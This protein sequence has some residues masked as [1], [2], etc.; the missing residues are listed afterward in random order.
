MQRQAFTFAIVA[1]VFAMTA[2]PSAH[3][4]RSTF[5]VDWSCGYEE[6]D[7]F[8]RKLKRANQEDLSCLAGAGFWQEAMPRIGGRM[9]ERRQRLRRL[10][11]LVLENDQE[12]E[13]FFI[14]E[15]EAGN[16]EAALWLL[17]ARGE[18]GLKES[19]R[20]TRNVAVN[21]FISLPPWAREQYASS[22]ADALLAEGDSRAA[23]TLATAMKTIAYLDQEKAQAAL[24]RGR[25]MERYGTVDEAVALYAEAIDLGNDR[26]SA[27]AELRKIALMW[28]SGYIKTEEAVAVLRELVT[29]WR[30]ENLG[31]GITLALARAYYFDEQL[32]QSLRLLASVYGSNA[33]EDIRQ[34]AE[35]RMISISEDLFVRRLDAAT[36]GDLMDVYEIVRPMVAP[37]DGFW[38]GDMRLSE[39]LVQAGLMARAELLMRNATPEGVFAAGGNVALI[40]ASALSIAFNQREQARRFLGA[41]P[42]QSLTGDTRAYFARLEA[43]ALEVE[44]LAGLIQPGVRRDVLNIISD[45][46]WRE[47]AY[48]LF[49]LARSYSDER[50]DW[51][52]PTATYLARGARVERDEDVI[53]TDPRIRALSSSPKP[54]VYHAEDLRPLLVPSAEVADLAATL[55][56]IGQTLSE[57]PSE[58]APED[59]DGVARDE[60][61]L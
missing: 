38:L 13:S 14:S 53:L 34:E 41:V 61:S 12:A 2:T 47:E 49:S 58:G 27:E 59:G 40:D 30:G 28:R 21:L 29:V 48:G 24:I 20:R 44:D 15:L 7:I 1:L 43:R 16:D 9:D 37:L 26:L 51:K 57:E 31:A 50:T 42:R 36:I 11:S 60:T 18:S 32:P 6:G 17:I 4:Q 3:A 39:V 56:R 54:S 52:E 5:G 33:P 23:L 25:V 10:L 55:T 22:L 19:N 46:A 35:R 8:V 45:R